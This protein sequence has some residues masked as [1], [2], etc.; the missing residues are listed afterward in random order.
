M[1]KKRKILKEE[2]IAILQEKD[3]QYNICNALIKKALNGDIKAFEVIRETIGENYK[4][5]DK[6]QEDITTRIVIV[7]DLPPDENELLLS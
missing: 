5:L 4:D 2:L 6:S 7:N 3:I 1:A